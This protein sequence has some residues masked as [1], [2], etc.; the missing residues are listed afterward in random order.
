MEAQAYVWMI[1]IGVLVLLN[2][3]KVFEK[4]K[5]IGIA[6]LLGGI[7]ISLVVFLTQILTKLDKLLLVLK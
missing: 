5:E 2:L 4:N 1:T 6:L 7:G 3:L